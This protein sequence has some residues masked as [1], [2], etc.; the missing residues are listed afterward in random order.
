MF[1]SNEDRHYHWRKLP[2]LLSRQ[3][4]VCHDDKSTFVTTNIFLSRQ[5]M[6]LSLQNICRYK[7]TF[8]ATNIILSCQNIFCRDKSMLVATN[9]CLSRQIFVLIN[10][11]SRQKYFVATNISLFIYM[12][13]FLVCFFVCFLKVINLYVFV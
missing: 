10:V 7:H 2:N 8:V 3:K 12:W 5:N 11:L 1:V 4:Y 6:I 13:V 9:T